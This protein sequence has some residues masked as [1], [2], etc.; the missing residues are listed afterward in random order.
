MFK[1]RFDVNLYKIPEAHNK[2][3][4]FECIDSGKRIFVAE[5]KE[6][7]WVHPSEKTGWL[8]TKED[9]FWSKTDNSVRRVA[10]K[11]HEAYKQLKSFD[12]PKVLILFN[13]DSL[14][15]KDLREA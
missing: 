2:T 15:I 8:K 4:D 5:L 10:D 3:P 12:T 13:T 11:I 14:D 6:F 7:V 9:S 1:E